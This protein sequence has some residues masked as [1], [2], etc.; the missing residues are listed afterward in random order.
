MPPIRTSP[1]AA[2]AAI[3]VAL[4]LV[5]AATSGAVAGQLITSRDIQNGTIRKVDLSDRLKAKVD[6]LGLPGP[7]GETGPMGPA[8]PAGSTGPAGPVG[9]SG[10]SGADGADG[11]GRLSA[12]DLYDTPN[13]ETQVLTIAD[14]FDPEAQA[15][16]VELGGLEPAGGTSALAQGSYLVTLRSLSPTLGAWVPRLSTDTGLDGPTPAMGVCLSLFV[17]CET[18]FPVVVGPG[19][20]RLEVYLGDIGAFL[21]DAGLLCDCVPPAPPQVSVSVIGVATGSDGTVPAGIPTL[22]EVVSRLIEQVGGL[23][24]AFIDTMPR[25]PLRK[26]LRRLRKELLS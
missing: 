9:P 2:A 23:A 11:I 22:D 21:V 8:G 14:P 26:E 7:Q 24:G 18:T 6:R 3:A 1:K 4:S 25:S 20:A 15:I 10:P 17:P 5:V 16:E 13:D 19:G 12:W